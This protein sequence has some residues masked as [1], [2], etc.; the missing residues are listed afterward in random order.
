MEQKE[1]GYKAVFTTGIIFLIISCIALFYSSENRKFTGDIFNGE[2]FFLINYILAVI[3]FFVVLT[4]SGRLSSQS[5]NVNRKLFIISVTLFSLSCFALNHSFTLFEKFTTWLDIYLIIYH[6]ALL[7]LIFIEKVHQYIRYTIYF[8][9]GTALILNLYFTIYLIPVMPI[10]LIG[11]IFLGLG[12]HAFAPIVIIFNIIINIKKTIRNRVEKYMVLAG[13]L[14]PLIILSVFLIQWSSFKSNIHKAS[15]ASVTRPNNTLPEWILLAQEIPDDSFSQMIVSA[16]ILYQK[17]SFNTG[18]NRMNSFGEVKRHN[19]LVVLAELFVGDVNLD[20][21]TR[22]K[23][24]KSQYNARHLGQRKL[25]TG[26]NLKT[27]DVLNNV[28]VYPEY[29]LA[30]SEKTLTI[31]NTVINRRSNQ[32]EAA[33]TFYLPEGSVA[34]SLSLW[35]NGV[36]EKSR[37]TTKSKADSAYVSIVGV[38]RRDPALMH[39]QEGNTLTVTIFPCTPEENRKFKI[40]ITSP[41]S[42]VDGRLLLPNIYFEGPETHDILETTM[43]DYRSERAITDLDIPSGFDQDIDGKYIYTGSFGPYWTT[44]CN[45]VPV[46]EK[47]FSFN[48]NIYTLKEYK[49]TYKNFTPNTV[50]LDINKSWS[51][52]EFLS[53]IDMYSNSK[54]LVFYDKN[55]E[56]GKH[57]AESIYEKF[58][59]HNFSLFPFNEIKDPE[60]SLVISKSTE[61]SPNIADLENTLFLRNLKKMAVSE[62]QRI[63]LFQ[64]G[65]T[66]SPYIKTLSEHQ[67][68][69]FQAG[70]IKDLNSL[71]ENSQFINA[72]VDSNTVNLLSSKTTIER[73]TDTTCQSVAPDHLLRLFAYNKIMQSLGKDHFNKNHNKLESLVAEANEAYIVSPVSSLIVLETLKDYERFD[74]D[75]NKNSL[76]NATVNSSGSVPEPSEWALIIILSSMVI[77]LIHKQRKKRSKEVLN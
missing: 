41:L 40:G 70:D 5:K 63:N 76:K 1:K 38:E 32:Q 62:N 57:N 77:F 64:I 27:I 23:I 24:L 66:S 21:Q 30:Y 2:N 61:L 56:V 28:V 68:F 31:K 65:Q 58:S 16:K 44:S 45:T 39:W 8:F 51:K 73:L 50:Y 33:Y 9:L 48:N 53:V 54:L 71:K 72:Q 60:N 47:P 26:K 7:S 3:Y 18:M 49:P 14:V 12:T 55:I 37:L 59:K 13:I 25:W 46:T 35:I 34:S 17:Y 6:L 43:I 22:M 69:N 4:Q 10:A 15:S 29:R 19:P 36:E 42:E 74:I 52:T 20:R 75:E 11:I 67:F